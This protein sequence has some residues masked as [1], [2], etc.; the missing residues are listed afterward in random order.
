LIKKQ[1]CK[2]FLLLI[3][4]LFLIAG[5]VGGNQNGGGNNPDDGDDFGGGPPGGPGPGGNRARV[6]APVRPLV[7]QTQ[8]SNNNGAAARNVW[9]IGPNGDFGQVNPTNNDAISC[10]CNGNPPATFR[11]VRKEGP[12]KGNKLYKSI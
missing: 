6:T 10:N 8:P 9:N 12:N 1:S 11:T 4:L 5:G 2:E 7:P 3:F